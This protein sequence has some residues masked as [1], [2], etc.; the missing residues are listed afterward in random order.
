VNKIIR[1][2]KN[3]VHCHNLYIG[4]QTILPQSS[5]GECEL[6]DGELA[7][8]FGAYNSG[9]T[10][11]SPTCLQSILLGNG[12]CGAQGVGEDHLSATLNANIG[13]AQ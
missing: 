3:E 5:S 4:E 11:V 12:N 6:T 13:Q 9:F 7:T 10:P 8:V 1:I 2:W